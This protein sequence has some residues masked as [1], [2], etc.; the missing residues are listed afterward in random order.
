MRPGIVTLCSFLAL[1]AFAAPSGVLIGVQGSDNTYRTIWIVAEGGVPAVTAVVKGLVVPRENGLWKMD[2]ELKTC[3]EVGQ[4]EVDELSIRPLEPASGTATIQDCESIARASCGAVYPAGGGLLMERW[5]SYAGPTHFAEQ[6]WLTE[7]CDAHPAWETGFS[8][9]DLDHPEEDVAMETV[10]QEDR[11]N[12]LQAAARAVFTCP[13][14]DLDCIDSRDQARLSLSSGWGIARAKGQWSVMVAVSPPD[15]NHA[16]SKLMTDVEAPVEFLGL[17]EGREPAATLEG[18]PDGDLSM[19]PEAD[20]V[21]VRADGVTAY[22]LVAGSV[23]GTPV[24]I[25]A[26]SGERVVMIEWASTSQVSPWSAVLQGLSD[27]AAR[28][29]STGIDRVVWLQGCWEAVSEDRIIEEHWM[30]PRGDSMLGVSRTVKEG[31]LVGYELVVLREQGDQLALE[32]HPSGQPSAVFV[33]S[34]IGEQSVVFEN[35]QHDFPQRIG[36]ER[37]GD[38]L[39]GWIEGR[40]GGEARRM[41]FPYRRAACSGTMETER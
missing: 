8:V 15:P 10:F 25:P 5:I 31:R 34:S 22:H 35:P 2:V 32:A 27:E 13:T 1:P 29:L 36:Y 38:D 3:G 16:P 39:L 40:Q 4:Y 6:F 14:D 33:S 11:M 12:A 28:S 17:S 20:M 26:G 21:I 41:E 24:P 9:H 23:E 19:S 7:T 30:A 18:L 37:Q